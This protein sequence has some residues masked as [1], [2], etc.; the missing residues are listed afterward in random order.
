MPPRRRAVG[1]RG[2]VQAHLTQLECPSEEDPRK[3][4]C[5]SSPLRENRIGWKQGSKDEMDVESF[6]KEPEECR[7]VE[8]RKAKVLSLE[9]LLQGKKRKD[10]RDAQAK[11]ET[12]R[13]EME[14]CSQSSLD[15]SEHI[16]DSQLQNHVREIEEQAEKLL[17]G[18]EQDDRTP[19]IHHA[20]IQ[21]PREL[22]KKQEQLME[23]QRELEDM[24]FPKRSQ[25][26]QSKISAMETLLQSGWASNIP[27]VRKACSRKYMD[28]LFQSMAFQRDMELAEAA[29][30]AICRLLDAAEVGRQLHPR[31]R[32]E[33]SF[34]VCGVDKKFLENVNSWSPSI[35]EVVKALEDLGYCGAFGTE[36]SRKKPSQ[37]RLYKDA[38]ECAE[39]EE[40]L[41]EHYESRISMVMNAEPPLPNLTFLILIIPAI[42]KQNRS[43]TAARKLFMI[44]TELMLDYRCPSLLPHLTIALEGLLMSFPEDEWLATRYH[45]VAAMIKIGPSHAGTLQAIKFLPVANPRTEYLKSLSALGLIGF[46]LNKDVEMLLG[47]CEG[48]SAQTILGMLGNPRVLV[49]NARQ[50]KFPNFAALCTIVDCS[51]LIMHKVISSSQDSRDNALQD[52]IEFLKAIGKHVK[53]GSLLSS[54]R[55][56][57]MATELVTAYEYI[58]N[59]R[60]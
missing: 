1:L 13:L 12:E 19:P 31:G 32:D 24:L 2:Q 4:V 30:V 23:R 34:F 54:N 25:E 51:D 44:C 11:E 3:D 40:K 20:V 48:I 29:F 15:A 52:W 22:L 41:Y 45:M 8:K 39:D 35:E 17:E 57:L 43:F 21:E 55:L 58:K 50:D 53:R 47:S 16:A 7:G 26:C 38:L 10:K 5:L 59:K 6:W 33:E 27:F 60:Q 9:Q 42:A 28:W 36:S 37:H 49:E 18:L 56:K 14:L 46:I